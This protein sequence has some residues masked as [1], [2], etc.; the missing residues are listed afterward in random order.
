MAALTSSWKL[1]LSRGQSLRLPVPG[2]S[3]QLPPVGGGAVVG[4]AVGVGPGAAVGAGPCA[5][6]GLVGLVGAGAG[7]SVVLGAVGTGTGTTTIG[8]GLGVAL[9][10]LLGLFGLVVLSTSWKMC[11]QAKRDTAASDTRPSGFQ[12]IRHLG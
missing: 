2:G 10:V 9:A 1:A 4:A 8:M 12:P 3:E 5:G 7:A 11:E 6:R